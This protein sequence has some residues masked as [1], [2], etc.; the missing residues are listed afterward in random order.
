MSQRRGAAGSRS[1]RRAVYARSLLISFSLATLAA[2]MLLPKLYARPVSLVLLT[3]VLVALGVAIAFHA[4]FL[5]LFRHEQRDTAQALK[6]TERE[7]QSIFDNAL[8]GLVILDDQGISIESN[9]AALAILGLK[10]PDLIGRP[11]REFLAGLDLLDVSDNR[12]EVELRLGDG[13]RVFIEYSIAAHYLPGRHS[14]VL[15]DISKRRRAEAE[16]RESRGQFVEMADHIAEVFWTLDARTKQVLYVNPAFETL[17]GRP[18]DTLRADPTSYRK[19]FH[20]EDTARVMA[21]FEEGVRTG[22]FDEE[23]RIVR[24]DRAIRWVWVRG[25]AVRDPSGTI[26]RL[27]GTAQDVTA[28]KSAEQEIARSLS[29]AQ[30]A[31]AEADALR[32]TTL[33]LTQNLSLDYVLD[34]LLASLLEL[35]PCD[36]ARVL[37]LETEDLLFSARELH[38]RSAPS[39]GEKLLT[40]WNADDHPTLRRVVA[41]QDTVL[42]PNTD[43]EDG[44]TQFSGHARFRSWLGV[45]LVASD[46]MLG[47]LSLGHSEA[48]FFTDEHMRLARSLAIPA[49]VAIQNARL[50]ERAEIYGAELEK[51]LSD[52]E[53]AQKALELAEKRS[54]FDFGR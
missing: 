35:V 11:M 4:C 30:S 7:F 41:T 9:P 42:V 19:L 16:L 10:R 23:F 34:T 40:T 3:L 50:Y 43:E 37:L 13:R 48:H 5:L 24:P 53:Q 31:W 39:G 51:R 33:A 52:L 27:V 46:Q 45:P 54:S 6:L 29:L 44:W 8:D 22:H 32:K 2:A 38:V 47:L 49:A 21:H 1:D 14:V 17:T 36:S 26:C 25:T 15:R 20:P 28:R 18:L 12:G